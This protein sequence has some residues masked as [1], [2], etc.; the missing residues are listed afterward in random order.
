MPD[1]Y[2][3]PAF[4]ADL[5]SIAAEELSPAK[6]LAHVRPL[7]SRFAHERTWLRPEHYQTDPEQGFLC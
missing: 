7:A 6:T 3:L 1:V 2:T 5:R 4:V